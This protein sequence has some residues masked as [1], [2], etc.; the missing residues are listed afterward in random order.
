[1]SLGLEGVNKRSW[2]MHTAR[3]GQ[4]VGRPVGT[5]GDVS[6]F[7]SNVPRWLL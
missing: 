3:A 4:L 5:L 1:M 6:L 2:L 7:H